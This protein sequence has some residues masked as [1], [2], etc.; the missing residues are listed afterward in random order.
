MP[1]AITVF[2]RMNIVAHEKYV[3]SSL[4]MLKV[5]CFVQEEK[6]DHKQKNR[7]IKK[8]GPYN[9]GHKKAIFKK[10]LLY[11]RDTRLICK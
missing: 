7:P 2:T 11:I 6:Y 8:Y 4:Y 3:C 1:K 9:G 5:V 10:C